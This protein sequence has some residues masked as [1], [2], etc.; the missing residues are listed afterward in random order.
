MNHLIQKMLHMPTSYD[1]PH[2]P[3]GGLLLIYNPSQIVPFGIWG[4]A[5]GKPVLKDHCRVLQSSYNQT[6]TDQ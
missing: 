6:L 3:C 1:D 2:I 5:L 4:S